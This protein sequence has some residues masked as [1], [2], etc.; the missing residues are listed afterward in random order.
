MKALGITEGQEK[1]DDEANSIEDATTEDRGSILSL[2]WRIEVKLVDR[3]DCP[4]VPQERLEDTNDLNL[5][6]KTVQLYR[7]VKMR[8]VWHLDNK[9]N[10]PVEI[11]WMNW[12]WNTLCHSCMDSLP[13]NVVQVLSGFTCAVIKERVWSSSGVSFPTK[14]SPKAVFPVASPLSVSK[15]CWWLWEWSSSKIPKQPD[16]VWIG[17]RGDFPTQSWFQLPHWSFSSLL[18]GLR[19]ITDFHHN[20]LVGDSLEPHLIIILLRSAQKT[21]AHS[22]LLTT[23][24][25]EPRPPDQP[26]AACSAFPRK[27]RT[28]IKK[29][30]TLSKSKT[31]TPRM[32]RM[33]LARSGPSSSFALT[34]APKWVY[35]ANRPS[36]RD[37][38]IR[39]ARSWDDGDTLE[40]DP[41]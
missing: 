2:Q 24:D 41:T 23:S 27:R 18:W 10:L 40:H 4:N 3:N 34:C 14:T 35:P 38:Q 17:K 9:S 29:C 8:D 19:G 37:R 22:V 33:H 1:A 13:W 26:Q 28:V 32:K 15:D 6:Q 5:F 11:S 12:S 39:A 25:L 20:H 21:H 36:A 30:R 31:N 7:R 16:W